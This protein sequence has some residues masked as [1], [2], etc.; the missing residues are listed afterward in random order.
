[1]KINVLTSSTLQLSEKLVSGETPISIHGFGYVGSAIA[2][3]FLQK[4]CSIIAHDIKDDLIQSINLGKWETA[5]DRRISEIIRKGFAEKKIIATTNYQEAISRSAFHII[6]VPVS[7]SRKKGRVSVD[8][9]LM[10]EA[11]KNIGKYME[12]GDAVSIETTLPPGTTEKV[13]KPL[14]EEESKFIAGEDFALI[15]SPERILVG[16]AVDDIVSNYPK[17]VA[18]F[19][20]KSLEI[21]ITLYSVVARKG[22]LKISSI[23]A[24]EAEKVFEGIYRDVNIALANELSDYCQSSDLNYW[25]IMNA[26]NSQ[27]YSHLHKPGVGVGGACIPVYPYFIISKMKRKLML[28]C[29]ARKINEERP[30]KVA[31]KALN[32]FTSKYGSLETAKITILGLSFRGDVAD[33]RLSPTIDMARYFS[34]RRYDVRVHDPY[35]YKDTNLP[36][37]VKFTNNLEEAL[38][39]TNIIILATDH[40]EYRKL[41]VD[42]IRDFCSKNSIIEDPKG[43]LT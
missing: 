43:I 41:T 39:E 4:G 12:R 36:K 13:L 30:K 31:K 20:Q 18:G 14:L 16:R 42:Q 27:P 1:M 3:A 23:K 9:S 6:T 7:I 5:D 34:R 35:T 17:I 26:A 33:N 11:C 29:E 37:N 8:L 19:G 22:V 24:A 2:S 21:G 10:V 25:E 40:H 38:K 15:Y 32:E 28:T